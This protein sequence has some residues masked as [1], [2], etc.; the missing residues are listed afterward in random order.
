MAAAASSAT[1]APVL[2]S[3]SVSSGANS[4]DVSGASGSLGGLGAVSLPVETNG[5]DP[6]TSFTYGLSKVSG[7]SKL[8]ASLFSAATAGNTPSYNVSWSG[9]SVGETV[10]A[11]WRVTASKTGYQTNSGTFTIGVTRTS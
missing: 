1:A 7:S 10:E 4:G 2:Y 8:S 11:T 5:P 9:L 6:T 3:I